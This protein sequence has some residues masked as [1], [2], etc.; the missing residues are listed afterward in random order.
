MNI[1]EQ[2]KS[3][4]APQ[5]DYSQYKVVSYS[6]YQNWAQCPHKWR[7]QYIDKHFTYFYFLQNIVA[8]G[9]H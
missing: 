6:Q 8:R 1:V 3:V 5:V 9:V 2:V 4:D 7:L